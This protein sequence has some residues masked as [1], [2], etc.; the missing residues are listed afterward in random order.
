[1]VRQDHI[2]RTAMETALASRVF[3]HPKVKAIEKAQIDGWQDL[4]RVFVKAFDDRGQ[5]FPIDFDDAWVWLAYGRKDSALR[6]LKVQFTEG[7][8]YKVHDDDRVNKTSKVWA[9]DQKGPL[10]DKYYLTT[11][12]FEL[13]ALRCRGGRGEAVKR[14]FLA[15][16]EA[17]FSA[18]K[19]LEESPVTPAS[20]GIL[21]RKRSLMEA[22]LQ[23]LQREPEVLIRVE[24]LVRDT[25]ASKLGAATE[26]RCK[27][28]VIDILSDSEIIEVKV[29][30]LW[31]HALG[32]CVSY[33]LCFPGRSRRLHLFAEASEWGNAKGQLETICEACS[34]FGVSVTLEALDK[35]YDAKSICQ[36]DL[37]IPVDK[38]TGS[39]ASSSI[40]LDAQQ[41]TVEEMEVDGTIKDME[42]TKAVVEPEVALS[43]SSSP[44]AHAEE[45]IKRFINDH[46]TVGVAEKV[47]SS[48]FRE[49][50]LATATSA[51]DV[52]GMRRVGMV[53]HKIG[54]KA[55][56]LKRDGRRCRGFE[57]LSVKPIADGEQIGGQVDW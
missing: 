30:R 17:Y 54:F 24:A 39:E 51:H 14:F 11:N 4:G 15:V 46:C 56:E 12:A 31:K 9:S 47:T 26:V 50:L 53:M 44:T 45:C 2:S 34:C 7:V 49:R 37:V 35:T 6:T 19:E 16:K 41:G 38:G 40:T 28:V 33:G 52:L 1:V 18:T 20:E 57:G 43:F 55:R 29:Y 23:E 3:D 48:E 21:K 42:T 36:T 32:Q 13:F 25:L 8:D 5:E 22:Q 10:P 27:Y